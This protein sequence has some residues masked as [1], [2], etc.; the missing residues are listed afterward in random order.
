MATI[1]EVK[2]VE[3]RF[4]IEVALKELELIRKALRS[5]LDM[6]YGTSR[7]Y[8]CTVKYRRGDGTLA[9]QLLSETFIAE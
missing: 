3:R 1:N 4:S 9:S 6:G 2:P 7:Q 5:A 8:D